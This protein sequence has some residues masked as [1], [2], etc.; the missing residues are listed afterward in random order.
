MKVKEHTF[1]FLPSNNQEHQ[2]KFSFT[3]VDSR[4]REAPKHKTCKRHKQQQSVRHMTKNGEVHLKRE[5][6]MANNSVIERHG[7]SKKENKPDAPFVLDQEPSTPPNSLPSNECLSPCFS[8]RI[9]SNMSP[10]KSRVHHQSFSP[11]SSLGAAEDGLCLPNLENNS[12]TYNMPSR[13]ASRKITLRPRFSPL[14]SETIHTIVEEDPLDLFDERDRG[15]MFTQLWM[16]HQPSDFST[17]RTEKCRPPRFAVHRK[18]HV[19]AHCIICISI[20]CVC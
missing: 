3:Y 14:E 8:R 20:M 12:Y 1:S 15:M 10:H 18:M 9:R 19:I 11:S 5:A 4:R 7:A 16:D 6:I 2:Q 17:S 13:N